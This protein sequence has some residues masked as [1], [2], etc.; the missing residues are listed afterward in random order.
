MDIDEATEWL[1]GEAD[2]TVRANMGLRYGIHTDRAF[3]MPMATMKA[4]AKELGT[5]HD[6]ALELWGT[7]WYEARI[8]A[9]MVDDATAVTAQ[10]MDTWC[11]EFDNWAICDTVCCNLFDRTEHRW[12]KVE[13]WADRD[14]EFVR[15][16]GFALLWALALHDK[17]ADDEQFVHGL[18]L[19]E[20]E[21]IDGRPMVNN[22]VGMA[23]RSIG[24]RRPGVTDAAVEVAR[25]LSTS[26]D[27][28]ARRIG[29]PA[30]KELQA[31]GGR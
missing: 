27:A 30:L 23:L 4:L 12:A 24:K 20:R 17:A 6:L 18:S 22:A 19:I 15:R 9:S 1:Q 10:Q 25:R 26:E 5:D 16:G 7:G 29:W 8:V 14:E 13:E 21:A 2:A 28:A 3:G 11:G 31:R